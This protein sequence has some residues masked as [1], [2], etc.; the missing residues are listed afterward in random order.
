MKQSFTTKKELSTAVRGYCGNNRQAKIAVQSKYGVKIG[1]W[2]VSKVTDMSGVFQHMLDFN[3]PINKWDVSHIDDF[4]YIFD[5][6][7]T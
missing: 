1:D 7:K 6:R 3:E 4:Y 5:D 2:D